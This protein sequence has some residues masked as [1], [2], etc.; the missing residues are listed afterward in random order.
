[1]KKRVLRLIISSFVLL[2]FFVTIVYSSFFL[3]SIFLYFQFVPSLITFLNGAFISLGFLLIIFLTVFFGRWY[4]SLI[5]PFGIFQQLIL[6]FIMIFKKFKRQVKKEKVFY[7]MVKTGVKV[8]FVLI[9]VFS[10]IT[11]FTFAMKFLDPF[12]FF[13]RISGYTVNPLF[14]FLRNKSA[15]LLENLNF[16]FFY[17]LPPRE[18]FIRQTVMSIIIIIVLF[19]IVFFFRRVWCKYICPVGVFL[20][21]VNSFSLFR[22]S[23]NSKCNSCGI[24]SSACSTNCIDFE[25]RKINTKDCVLCFNCESVCKFN[26]ISYGYNRPVIKINP[27]IK[28]R[29]II[30]SLTAGVTSLIALPLF[31]MINK[32]KDKYR[33]VLPPGAINLERFTDKCTSCHL[34]ISHCPADII[35]PLMFQN[36]ADS[37]MLPVLSY[38]D[39]FCHFT[40]T[41]CSDICPNDALINLSLA[42]KQVTCLGKAVLR[43]HSCIVYRDGFDCAACS[44]HCPTKAVYTVLY[45]GHLHAPVINPDYCIGC[46]ACEYACPAEP[47]KAIIVYPN[48]IQ[49]TAKKQKSQDQYQESD[50]TEDFPF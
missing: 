33:L 5:C 4:C 20:G 10:I 42:S 23:I 17:P 24:C 38:R 43:K 40:C 50:E 8:S 39:D 32:S 7:A 18:F 15:M 26:A 36:G 1:M 34:C 41:N 37:F 25:N 11:G 14:A 47:H 16:H 13:A 6:D 12:S 35:K 9:G 29:F 44:E 30:S 28:R 2:V 49:D 19:I 22:M 3:N 48:D 46:G 27:D 21:W 45:A 31:S